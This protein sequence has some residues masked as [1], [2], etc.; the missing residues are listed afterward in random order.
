[1]LSACKTGKLDEV[2]EAID[3]GFNTESTDKVHCV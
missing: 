2:V 1:M 3:S